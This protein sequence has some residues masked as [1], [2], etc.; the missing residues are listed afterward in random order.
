MTPATLST[1]TTAERVRSACAGTAAAILAA[2]SAPP[3]AA[4]VHQLMAEGSFALTVPSDSAIVGAAACAGTAGTEAVL[5]LTDYAPLPLREPVRSLV[6]I[7]G[8]VHS[9]PPH[10]LRELLDLIAATRPDPALLEVGA[11]QTLLLLGADSVSSPIPPARA[12]R[13]HRTA[14]RRTG[15][16]LRNGVGVAAASRQ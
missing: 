14:G 2:D 10:A 12:R 8:R 13:T 4:P 11:G 5:E 1:P 3:A 6:W 15:P 16:V 9:V 7:R